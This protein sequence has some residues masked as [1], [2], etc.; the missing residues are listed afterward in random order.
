[1]NILANDGIHPAGQKAALE[2]AGHKLVD[3]VHRAPKPSESIHQWTMPLTVCWY[4]VPPKC[5]NPLID[6]CP[7]SQDSSYA[8]GLEWTTL[9]LRTQGKT[10]ER[11][12]I[13]RPQA[14]KVWLNW[15][16]DTSFR[17][18]RSLA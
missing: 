8:E 3:R 10:A 14:H 7:Q 1:M 2:A 15:S 12:A 4:E 9:M 6:A 16:W 13:R 11:S 17:I 5:D 18:S